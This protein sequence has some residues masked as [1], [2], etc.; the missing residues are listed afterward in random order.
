MTAPLNC[1]KASVR[2]QIRARLKYLSA[3][4]RDAAAVALCSRLREQPVW[5]TARSVLLFAPRSDEPDLW[6]LLSEAIAVGKTVA[7]PA[8]IAGMNQYTARQILDP[9]RDL[10]TGQ[11]SIREP[12][13]GCPEVPLNRLDLA[14]IPGVAFDARGS[15]LGRGQGYYDRLL[16]AVRGTKCGVAFEEQIVDVVPVGPRDIRLNCILTPTRWIET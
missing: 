13:P 10:M 4:A 15:R 12:L 9:A 5:L 2:E 6:P 11:F 3:E 8:F 14:L 1:A 16:V 7:L